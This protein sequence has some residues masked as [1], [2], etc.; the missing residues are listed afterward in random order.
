ME[1]QGG[2]VGFELF[3][4]P[5]AELASGSLA[6]Q[7]HGNKRVTWSLAGLLTAGA[8]LVSTCEIFLEKKKW[9]KLFSC[10]SFS[11]KSNKSLGLGKKKKERKRTFFSAP[12]AGEG[13]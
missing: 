5:S 11:R 13:S 4:G 1:E 7:E 9:R 3:I 8:W 12:L 2:G 10:P 6:L